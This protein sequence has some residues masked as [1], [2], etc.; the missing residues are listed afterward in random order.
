ME[1]VLLSAICVKLLMAIGPEAGNSNSWEGESSM[2]RTAFK[3]PTSDGVVQGIVA[4][5][6]AASKLLVET[7][8]RARD[9][10]KRG[11][12]TAEGVINEAAY[13]IKHAPF[14]SVG[15][16]FAV[17]TLAGVLTGMLISRNRERWYEVP[18]L[19]GFIECEVNLLERNRSARLSFSFID[20][21]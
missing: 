16:A 17:G 7:G 9:L 18:P 1:T 19:S 4:S 13:K 15:A 14:G 5:R 6:K 3:N 8:A 10:M 2:Q 21:K 20:R 11:R 12:H